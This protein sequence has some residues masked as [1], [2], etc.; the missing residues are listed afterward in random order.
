MEEV[1][2]TLGEPVK[3]IASF[4][5]H[6]FKIHFFNWKERTYPVE[7]MNLFH[8]ERD[9]SKKLYHFA[10]SSRGNSYELVFD[11]VTLD[12]VLADMVQV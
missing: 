2:T 4:S 11:P 7:S 12:W 10:V 5:P 9:G 6:K 1:K 8:I 3:V